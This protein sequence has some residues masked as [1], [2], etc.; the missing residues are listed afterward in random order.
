MENNVDR[1][2]KLEPKLLTRAIAHSAAIK[3]QVVSQGEKEK[4]RRHTALN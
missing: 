3:A 1:L 2:A 4:E